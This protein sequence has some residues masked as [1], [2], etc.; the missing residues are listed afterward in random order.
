MENDIF[1][2]IECF[3]SISPHRNLSKGKPQSSSNDGG[4]WL[5]CSCGEN[6]IKWFLLQASSNSIENLSPQIIRQIVKEMHQRADEPPE[7]IRVQLNDADVTDIQALI[8]GPASTPYS[9]GA[10]RVKLALGRDFPKEPPK[11][12]F[13]TKIFHPNVAPSGEICVNTLKRDWQP[14]LGLKHILLTIK[15]LLICPNAESALNE[16]AGKMLLERYDDYSH[17]AQLITSIHAQG[18]KLQ[19]FSGQTGGA[20]S[21]TSS[22]SSASGECST[23]GGGGQEDNGPMSKKHALENKN[24]IDKKK[25]KLIK[26]KKRILKRL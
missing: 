14:D 15:C 4:K 8:E 22:G 16:E 11:A 20:G 7:G 23:G 5:V 18:A 21:G 3:P 17:R 10:F 1:L 6:G 12:Y 26:E 13:L 19:F 24:P 25:D 2:P 9:G